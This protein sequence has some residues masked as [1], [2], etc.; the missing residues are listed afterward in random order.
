MRKALLDIRDPRWCSSWSAGAALLVLC[1]TVYVPGFTSLPTIDRDEARFAQASRQMFESLALP[2][3]RT[4]PQRHAGGAV[5]PMIQDRPRLNKPPLIYWLQAAS[6]AAL[7][8]AEPDRDAVWMY[9]IP[10]LIAACASVLMLWRLGLAMFDPRA[11]VLAAA[12]LALCPVFVWE[13]RQARADHLLT[14]C[15]TAAMWALWRL[16]RPAHGSSPGLRWALLLWA[17]VGLGVLAKGPITPMV[18][19]LTAGSLGLLTR[20]WDVIRTARPALGLAVVAAIVAPWVVLLADRYGLARYVALVYD[21]TIGRAGSAREGHAGPPGYH[22]LI[23]IV[24]F[25]PGSMVTGMAVARAWTRTI[26]GVRPWA[27][28]AVAMRRTRAAE[29]FCLCWVVPSWVIFE[30][31]ATKLPHYVM[32]LYPALALLSARTLLAASAG[33]VRTAFG[34]LATSVYVLWLGVGAI[35]GVGLLAASLLLFD[36]AWSGP[37]RLALPLAAAMLLI[38]AAL[39][40]RACGA[41][42]RRRPARAM[43]A[44]MA[45]AAVLWATVLGV[46]IPHAPSLWPTPA[47][48]RSLRS[49]DPEGRRPVATLYHEDSLIFE[50][51]GEV[52]RV[53]NRAALATYLADHPGALVVMRERDMDPGDTL[54]TLAL[55]R[56]FNIARF[57]RERLA[58]VEAAP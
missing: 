36:A 54:R 7:T 23:L 51:R 38:Q 6:A 22:L 10:S 48:V 31:S 11:A 43:R 9:R 2:P 57:T 55:I 44:A 27:W 13:V 21:E 47:I 58:I 41:I 53:R 56:G 46:V 42:V 8:G 19:L 28:R 18:A 39:L 1:L 52:H 5:V 14:A 3:E 4:D 25:W 29:L 45:M 16:W 26:R 32:P 20:R 35:A 17:S 12:L 34:R 24:M 40:A 30:I 15:T 33:S 37:L 50:T 49:I